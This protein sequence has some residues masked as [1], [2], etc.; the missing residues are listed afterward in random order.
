[1]ADKTNTNL[2]G[3]SESAVCALENEA[4]K[5]LPSY[6]KNLDI[7]ITERFFENSN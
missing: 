7:E 5:A 6:L 3:L 2:G 4:Y 1:V